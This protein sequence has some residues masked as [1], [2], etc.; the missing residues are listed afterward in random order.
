M[1]W[2]LI[3]ELFGSLF[4][5]LYLGFRSINLFNLQHFGYANTVAKKLYW[6]P[7]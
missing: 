4:I 5:A 7:L 3:I 2:N 1:D 6:L